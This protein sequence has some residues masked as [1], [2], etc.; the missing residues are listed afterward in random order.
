MNNDKNLQETT[1]YFVL[2]IVRLG[3]NGVDNMI[4]IGKVIGHILALE[5]LVPGLEI[6]IEAHTYDPTTT[7]A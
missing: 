2:E 1:A 4:H 5:K 7:D 3:E 6:K